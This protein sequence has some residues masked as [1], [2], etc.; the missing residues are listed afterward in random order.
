MRH[1]LETRAAFAKVTSGVDTPGPRVL[2][3]A[4]HPDDEIIGAGILLGRLL[5]AHVVHAT[6]GVPRSPVLVPRAFRGDHPA[7]YAQTRRT[8]ALSA[9]AMAGIAAERV[10]CLMLTDQDLALLLAA[11][12]RELAFVFSRIAPEIVMTHPYEGGHPDHDSCAFSCRA[13][14]DAMINRGE[15]APYLMEM[16]SYHRGPGGELLTARFLH[17][18]TS[19]PVLELL[20]S[21]EEQDRK[22]CMLAAHASQREVLAPFAAGVERFRPAPRYAFERP[23]HAGPL[24]YESLGWRM[25]GGRFCRLAVEALQELE[26]TGLSGAEWAS[27][28]A[29]S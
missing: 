25:S 11:L 22:L 7:R 5:H 28:C 9:L 12:A 19:E 4:A 24:H 27:R 3:V 16:T 6:W 21:A 14:I 26:E 29:P 20:P 2:I 18:N 23:P 10:E 13:A 8:E 17:E 1:T 15:Q